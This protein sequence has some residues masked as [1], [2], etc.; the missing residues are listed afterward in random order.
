[1]P[2]PVVDSNGYLIGI[3]TVDDML[4]VAEEEETED[5]QKFGG[6]EALEEP[7]MDLPLL[8]VIKKGESG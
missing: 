3:V 2:L 6:I 8:Q 4:D 1:M 5:I 7:Y